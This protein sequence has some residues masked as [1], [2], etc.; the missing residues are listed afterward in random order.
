MVALKEYLPASLAG[1][2]AHQ[3]VSVRWQSHAE[4]VALGLRSFIGEGRMLARF[5]HPG[6]LKVHRFWEGNSTACMVMPMLHG[7]PLRALR[8]AMAESPDEAWLRRLQG[9]L[10]GPL[11]VLHQADVFHRDIAPDNLHSSMDGA[12]ILLD[13]G[14]ARQV[15]AGRSARPAARTGRRP[16]RCAAWKHKTAHAT[17]SDPGTARGPA[18][19]ALRSPDAPPPTRPA[20]PV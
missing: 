8:Q 16:K 1:R 14:A 12:P 3:Q 18:L 20:R 2:G 11:E 7:Q 9:G 13:F 6:L 10:L 5:D 4:T 17:C 15:I 19:G